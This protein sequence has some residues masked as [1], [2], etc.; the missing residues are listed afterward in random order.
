MTLTGATLICFSM[1]SRSWSGKW[2]RA[3]SSCTFSSSGSTGADFDFFQGHIDLCVLLFCACSL[4]GSSLELDDAVPVRFYCRATLIVQNDSRVYIWCDAKGGYAD[5]ANPAIYQSTCGR[6]ESTEP[7]C[8]KKCVIDESGSK[9]IVLR[10]KR[11]S[12]N[13]LTVFMTVAR[14]A[15]RMAKHK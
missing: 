3:S 7:S 5:S 12:F 6:G 8:V 10:F 15:R 1:I 11:S 9:V 4:N 14:L 2:L 13:I